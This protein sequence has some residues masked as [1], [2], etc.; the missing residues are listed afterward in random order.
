MFD[1]LILPEI[2]A[3]HNIRSIGGSNGLQITAGSIFENGI[4]LSIGDTTPLSGVKLKVVGNVQSTGFVKDGGMS[5][6]FLKANGSVDSSDYVQAYEIP[7]TEQIAISDETTDLTTGTSKVTFRSP[8]NIEASLF[9]I[10]CATAPVGSVLTVDINVDGVSILSTKL[11]IDS[12]EKTS[13]TA[14]TA[15]QFVTGAD[16]IGNDAEITVDEIGVGS[17]IAGAGLKLIMYY[18]YAVVL[19]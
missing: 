1:L 14:A 18:K 17:F 3:G 19:P 10:S 11:T 7:Y 9:R 2:T 12:L 5:S 15:M 6:Q 16:E 13:R 8:G 4:G